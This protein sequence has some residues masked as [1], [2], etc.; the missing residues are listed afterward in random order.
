MAGGLSL[1]GRDEEAVQIQVDTGWDGGP[2]NLRE[3]PGIQDK[4]EG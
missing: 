4:Q 3:G 2:G 1:V